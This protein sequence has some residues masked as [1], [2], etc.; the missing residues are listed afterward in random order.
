MTVP[1]FTTGA[2]TAAQLNVLVDAVN[3]LSGQIAGF[4]YASYTP[5]W[6][7]STTNPVIGNG[8]VFGFYMQ[9]G[10]MVHCW[11]SVT[12]G[13][14]TTFGSGTYRLSLPVAADANLIGPVGQFH[15]RKVATN[16]YLAAAGQI[17]TSTTISISVGST[18]PSNSSW[19]P[20]TPFTFA[21]GDS[22][23]WSMTYPAA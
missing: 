4:T 23:R 13:S 20:T 11:G 7:G 17:V 1:H 6:T 16:D 14:T 18:Y 19:Q 21:S 15:F 8:V 10:K 12:A 2:A 9:L 3:A 5:V 22:C